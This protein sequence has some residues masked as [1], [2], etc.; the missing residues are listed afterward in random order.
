MSAESPTAQ[1]LNI[2]C[3]IFGFSSVMLLLFLFLFINI[4]TNTLDGN[5]CLIIY[6]LKELNTQATTNCAFSLFTVSA[7]A[8]GYLTNLRFTF[9][10][11]SFAHGYFTY[12][13][14]F[15]SH[16]ESFTFLSLSFLCVPCNV[17]HRVYFSIYITVNN[18]L[19]VCVCRLSFSPAVCSTPRLAL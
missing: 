16:K 5:I 10:I 1:V 12:T 2:K 17:H 4:R 19:F 13:N 15:D 6:F 7:T 8:D 11:E 14:L 9:S 18:L 3:D